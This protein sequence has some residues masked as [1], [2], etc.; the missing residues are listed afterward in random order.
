MRNSI[1]NIEDIMKNYNESI[2]KIDEKYGIKD[3]KELKEVRDKIAHF[4]K[5]VSTLEAE[6][7]LNNEEMLNNAKEKLKKAIEEEKEIQNDSADPSLLKKTMVKL[8]SGR[9]VTM[10]EKDKLDKEDIKN[11]T[12]RNLSLTSKDIS[13]EIIEKQAELEEKRKE[14]N[15]FKYE[16]D[17]ETGK[18]IN[19]DVVKNIHNDYDRIKEELVSLND[20]Q[21]KCNSYL[22]MLK[23]RTKDDIK[24][25]EAINEK[26]RAIKENDKDKKEEKDSETIEKS[27]VNSDV[28]VNYLDTPAMLYQYT[29]PELART[30]GFKAYEVKDFDKMLKTL[31]EEGIQAEDPKK[32][33]HLTPEALENV[34][35]FL[36]DY[37][38]NRGNEVAARKMIEA[39]N[40]GKDLREFRDIISYNMKG[41]SKLGFRSKLA[42]RKIAL[43]AIKNGLK[44]ENAKETMMWWDKFLGIGKKKFEEKEP[45]KLL[46][47]GKIKDNDSE[48]VDSIKV[49]PKDLKNPIKSEPSPEKEAEKDKDGVEPEDK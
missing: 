18:S 22:D 12:I 23:V 29:D 20:T 17:K 26:Y 1:E 46:T 3:S 4:K 48:F 35:P 38:S 2:K 30:R 34:D 36:I 28:S 44:V 14:W 31:E 6:G 47:D 9:E 39:L 33:I 42:Y 24:F 49:D 43:R 8:P 13:K 19:D 21:L 25:E 10:E 11:A 16:Y 15:D 5:L 27:I 45:T 41:V 37:L 32:T 7:E 40:K